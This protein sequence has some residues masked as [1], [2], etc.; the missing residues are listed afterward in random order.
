[1]TD[2]TPFV[3]RLR[4]KSASNL[5]VAD[6]MSS[7]P[8]VK[9]RL[10]DKEIGR[11]STINRS[12]NPQW[13]EDFIA[14]VLHAHVTLELKIYDE[15]R[16]QNPDLLGTVS[17]EL[18]GLVGRRTDGVYAISNAGTYK[19]SASIALVI[20]FQRNLHLIALTP[21]DSG[22]AEK[23]RAVQDMALE[24]INDL[25]H[26]SRWARLPEIVQNTFLDLAVRG[27][28]HYS[29]S[30]LLEDLLSDVSRL[31]TPT[32]S[33][34]DGF[35]RR[36]AL[37]LVA[38]RLDLDTKKTAHSP[39]PVEPNS[40]QI[41]LS[42]D[43]SRFILITLCSRLAVW[44][45]A[46]LLRLGYDVS[47]GCGNK[48]PSALPSPVLIPHATVMMHGTSRTGPLT[49]NLQAMQLSGVENASIAHMTGIVLAASSQPK[50]YAL[51]LV[52][53]P[54]AKSNVSVR[55][56]EQLQQLHGEQSM[57]VDFNL[58]EL[59]SARLPQDAPAP[60][61]GVPPKVPSSLALDVYVSQADGREKLL[62]QKSIKVRHLLATIDAS[63]PQ[64]L[65][66]TWQHGEFVLDSM[67]DL[68]ITVDS[69]AGLVLP[70]EGMSAYRSLLVKVAVVDA[71]GHHL[72]DCEPVR[73]STASVSASVDWKGSKCTLGNASLDKAAAV[74]C[75]VLAEGLTGSMHLGCAFI[76]LDYFTL[77]EHSYT[78]PLSRFN[79][80]NTI[81]TAA[82]KRNG[83]DGLGA[84]TVRIAKKVTSLPSQQP[85]SVPYTVRV[86]ESSLFNNCWYAE[87][88]LPGD[89]FVEQQT[90]EVLGAAV[91][92]EGLALLP[93]AH[94]AS[95]DRGNWRQ[96]I[97][98]S[99][100]QAVL[101]CCRERASEQATVLIPWTSVQGL[102]VI[103][104]DLLS[105]H[106]KVERFMGEAYRP[107]EVMVFVSNCP[108][109]EVAALIGERRA[110]Q[111]YAQDIQ[112][113]LS[114]G[115]VYGTA[116]TD[117]LS[118][119]AQVMQLLDEEISRYVATQ[120]T[121]DSN[122]SQ[123][124]MSRARLYQAAL[125]GAQLQCDQDPEVLLEADCER[126]NAFEQQTAVSTANN[127]IE[128]LLDVA[129]Q[130]IRDAVI[131][132]LADREKM[133]HALQVFINGYYTEIVGLLTMIFD[134]TG[135]DHASTQVTPTTS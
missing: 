68:E 41:N 17:L 22:L 94:P 42:A 77:T 1:M 38:Q 4:I 85:L 99:N 91:L 101:A 111:G 33:V 133:L 75:E 46:R 36:S 92:V 98:Q 66:D 30:E 123:R 79:I 65:L 72:K 20:D 90:V 50:A 51:E 122:R 103:T 73:T 6:F 37:Q 21:T 117:E 113:L 89:L 48:K 86:H 67:T 78:F 126:A 110:F 54:P 116:S 53:K 56:G 124:R 132:G 81:L 114:S 19:V 129:E 29:S 80:S 57:M 130:R 134:N 64:L 2:R 8:F 87:S 44:E 35:I 49:V 88:M 128:F 93:H 13:N 76:P 104:P 71:L 39:C 84:L 28:S 52:L 100:P 120:G 63:N 96:R 55:C 95:G 5:P 60:G 74:R 62:A 70:A 43:G 23:R 7:D 9:I 34:C 59:N 16:G 27:Y 31:A 25:R 121:L 61:H 45:L 32:P 26:D 83:E 106:C 108:A 102:Q 107:V 131:C 58:S 97:Y 12:L 118:P 18:K 10:G 24:P 40:L 15:D 112:A 115:T 82:S 105:V 109:A 119:A 69:A 127:R 47:N 3:L 11:T 14:S 135:Q 125:I